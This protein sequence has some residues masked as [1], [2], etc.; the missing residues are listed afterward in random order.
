MNY[1]MVSHYDPEADISPDADPVLL[2]LDYLNGVR[3]G[4]VGDMQF[5]QPM[6]QGTISFLLTLGGRK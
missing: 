2:Y 4:A 3:E 5:R 1:S 6:S